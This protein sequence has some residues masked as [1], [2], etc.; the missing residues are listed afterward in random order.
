[1][2]NDSFKASSITNRQLYDDSY[3]VLIFDLSRHIHLPSYLQYLIEYWQLQQ[4]LASLN[5]V[6]W[7]TFL[8]DHSDIVE[9][10][11]KQNYN[12]INF[13]IINRKDK[14]IKLELESRKET[15]R[16]RFSELL[17]SNI[18][19][20]YAA[21]YDWELF[22]KYAQLLEVD[23]S[24]IINI[25]TYLPLLAAGMN[26]PS[27]ILGIYFGPSFH[28]E[29]LLNYAP[30]KQEKARSF[31]EKFMLSR[32]LRN[33]KLQTL[34]CLD[35]FAV[36]PIS[37]ISHKAKVLHL[38]DPVKLIL[39][40]PEQ[41]EQLK[42]Y[43]E[44]QSNRKI[45]L[46]FGHLTRRKGIDQLLEAVKFLPT[47][48]H[49]QICLLLVGCIH[50]DYQALIETKIDWIHRHYPIQIVRNYQFVPQ[51]EVSFYFHLA[52]IVLAPYQHH[53]GMSGILLL[54]AAAQKPLL[55]SNYGLMGEIIQRY[56]LGISIDST[57]PE[58]IAKGFINCVNKSA[59]ELQDFSKAKA[60][61]NENSADKFAS[62]IFQS[63]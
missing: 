31:R 53:V 1:M 18:V 48:I 22:C 58:E 36:E 12:N 10:A 45:F 4:F 19:S 57:M 17:N 29:Q 40:S 60:F 6:V 41:L 24:F 44:I 16:A 28:Y 43:L 46:L 49:Q 37:K 7:H 34:F 26:C 5:I 55:S 14:E 13:L 9:L 15:M 8:I 3:K 63:F 42:R 11:S 56:S 61:A 27:P 25:D 38:P 54:A 52:D 62:T 23:K 21:L 33:P 32:A 51:R 30:K 39:P 2:T 35:P 59:E 47:E 50:P 20:D